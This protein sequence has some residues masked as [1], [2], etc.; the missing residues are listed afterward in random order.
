MRKGIA[1]LRELAT[2]KA[3]S[4][5]EKYKVAMIAELNAE[6]AEIYAQ[7]SLPGIPP[8]VVAVVKK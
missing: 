8:V 2:V 5:E 7:L 1:V 4:V 6:L 3:S